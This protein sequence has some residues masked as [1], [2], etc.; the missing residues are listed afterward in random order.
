MSSQPP[1]TPELLDTPVVVGAPTGASP[2]PATGPLDLLAIM[3]TVILC[4]S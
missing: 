2:D 1:N 3:L 4:L